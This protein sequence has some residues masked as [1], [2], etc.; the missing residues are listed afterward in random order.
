MGKVTLRLK[1]IR[2]FSDVTPRRLVNSYRR[3][4]VL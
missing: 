1:N 4:D 3:C 2:F